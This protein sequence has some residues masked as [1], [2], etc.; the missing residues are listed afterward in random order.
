MQP[1]FFYTGDS[2]SWVFLRSL[3]NES[4]FFYSCRENSCKGII[5]LAWNLRSL[6]IK[7]IAKIVIFP[8][9]PLSSL[10]VIHDSVPRMCRFPFILLAYVCFPSVDWI[11][12]YFIFYFPFIAQ[13]VLAIEL[14]Q[15]LSAEPA[16]QRKWRG[17]SSGDSFC[18]LTKRNNR[19]ATAAALMDC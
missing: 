14:T 10:A 15:S 18:L 12:H 13:K 5:Y 4:N 2:I 19:S 8:L 9:P 1:A 7:L 16:R 11:I 6:L 17:K 3:E